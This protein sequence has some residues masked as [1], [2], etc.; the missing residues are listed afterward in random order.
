MSAPIYHP[1]ILQG[2]DEWHA[3]RAGKWTASAGAKIMGGLETQG[4]KDL[5][6]DLAWG[7]V[8]GKTDRGYSGA[9]M[10]RGHEIEPEAR[11]NFAFA[12]DTEVEQVGFVEHGRI[13]FLGWSPDGLH[14]NRTRG[15]EIKSLEHKA[16]IDFEEARQVPSEYRWQC[17]IA[18]MVGA[19]DGLDFYVFHP[20]AGGICIPVEINAS[21]ADQIEGRLTLLETRVQARVERLLNFKGIAA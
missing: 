5:V 17:K 3:I 9:S 15:L 4:L 18:G 1:D 2:T 8:F 14:A 11:E 7:R 12:H 21:D 10:Q 20:L 6:K 19:L 13:P 16:W